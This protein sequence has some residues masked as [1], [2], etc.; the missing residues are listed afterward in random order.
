M[1]PRLLFL[2]YYKRVFNTLIKIIIITIKPR[3]AFI[4][5]IFT[6]FKHLNYNRINTNKRGEKGVSR[7]R[8]FA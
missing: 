5:L 6:Q 8:G 3:Y 7:I 1:I 4:S 2:K